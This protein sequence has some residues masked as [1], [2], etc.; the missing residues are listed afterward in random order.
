[1]YF[2]GQFELNPLEKKKDISL[3]VLFRTI[4]R[5]NYFHLKKNIYF[6]K[7]S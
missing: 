5:S 1:M 6:L 3:N 7:Y 2:S 4:F